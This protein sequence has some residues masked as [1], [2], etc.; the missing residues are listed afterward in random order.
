MSDERA[1]YE[2]AEVLRALG[3]VRTP[4]PRVLADAREALW[5]AIASETPD[6]RETPGTSRAARRQANQSPAERKLSIGG[7]D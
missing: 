6:A 5:L 7:G 4:A 1:E 2:A 3:S